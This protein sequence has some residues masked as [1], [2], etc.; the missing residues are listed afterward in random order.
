MAHG[1]AASLT[2]SVTTTDLRRTSLQHRCAGLP[3]A[4]GGYDQTGPEMADECSDFFKRGLVNAIGGCC[5]S[6]YP[7]IQALKERA[8][9]FAPRAKHDV[10]QIMRISG[11]EALNYVPNVRP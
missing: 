10:D 5:G 8:S 9:Q 2:L 1:L 4:M 11:L 7:H 3:N 6:S